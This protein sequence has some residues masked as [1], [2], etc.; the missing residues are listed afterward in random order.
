[1][2]DLLGSPA[3]LE[4]MSQ[5]TLLSDVTTVFSMEDNTM[6]ESLPTKEE[7]LATLTASNLHATAG[8]D[9]IPGLI[10]KE[11]WSILGDSLT[12]VVCSL[13]RPTTHH[14]YENHSDDLQHQAQEKKITQSK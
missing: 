8:T 3:V 7:V 2:R 9:G 12:D 10:Y 5:D 4:P 6:L 14:I 11:C 13:L 1:M